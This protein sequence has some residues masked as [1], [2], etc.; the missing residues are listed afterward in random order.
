V[1]RMS[2]DWHPHPLR[3]NGFCSIC[4]KWPRPPTP[5]EGIRRKEVGQSRAVRGADPV[6]NALFDEVIVQL[7]RSK[8]PFTSEDVIE[9]IGLPASGS[10]SA[11]GAKMTGAAK[12]GLIMKTGRRVKATRSIRHAGELTE[13]VGV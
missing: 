11:V 9:R 12:R 4:F 3:S 13:W 1:E 7:A 2:V 6:W 10:H 5:A 8:I